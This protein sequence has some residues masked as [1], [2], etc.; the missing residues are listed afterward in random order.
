MHG[1]PSQTRPVWCPLQAEER[2]ANTQYAFNILPYDTFPG[3]STDTFTIIR[4]KGLHSIKVTLLGF[5]SW[6]SGSSFMPGLFI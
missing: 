1:P 3:K 4:D 2:K 5:T 6:I